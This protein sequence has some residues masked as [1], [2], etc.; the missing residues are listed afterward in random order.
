M[1]RLG[2]A[3]PL[4][5][6]VGLAISALAH[7]DNAPVLASSHPPSG[8][9]GATVIQGTDVADDV[10][11][12]F[13]RSATP[14]T[15]ATNYLIS[16]PAG[17]IPGENCVAISTTEVTCPSF[18]GADFADT[19]SAVLAAPGDDRFE[20]SGDFHGTKI[21]SGIGN[22][23]IFGGSGRDVIFGEDGRDKLRGRDGNDRI[24]AGLGSD[25]LVGGAGNDRLYADDGE[26]DKKI[27]CGPGHDVAR[28][29]HGISER[30]ASSESARIWLDRGLSGPP[31][32]ERGHSRIAAIHGEF[33]A[34]WAR[35]RPC[36]QT[37]A[38]RRFDGTSRV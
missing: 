34:V 37:S 2:T 13:Q 24:D 32:A 31:V 11:A 33:A 22:D 20:F 35:I 23:Q 7:A 25:V 26:A 36:A 14:T 29:D 3:I 8:G 16:D 28:I 15:S 18:S 5:L 12:R 9:P 17:V 4:V 10:S 19:F 6:A 1:R 27:K 38:R 21:Y 30:P